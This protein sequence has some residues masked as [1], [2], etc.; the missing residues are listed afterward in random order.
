MKEEGGGVGVLR[1]SGSKNSGV[2]KS[3]MSTSKRLG[4]SG[5]SILNNLILSSEEIDRLIRSNSGIRYIAL[6]MV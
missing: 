6:L 4:R 2:Q 5:S 1:T 3:D